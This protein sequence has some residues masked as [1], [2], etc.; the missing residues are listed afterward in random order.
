ML[1]C[2]SLLLRR[3]NN[4]GANKMKFIAIST[5]I[6]G[7]AFSWLAGYGYWKGLPE[8]FYMSMFILAVIILLAGIIITPWTKPHDLL[9]WRVE[10]VD[11]DWAVRHSFV[12]ASSERDAID[13]FMRMPASNHKIRI[14]SVNLDLQRNVVD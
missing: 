4:T 12:Y 13:A 3:Q 2:E 7:V 9:T 5:L 14:D 1:N 8:P 10:W 11:I 6:A